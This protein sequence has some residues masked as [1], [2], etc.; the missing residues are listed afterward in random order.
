M[1]RGREGTVNVQQGYKYIKSTILLV[2]SAVYS[3]T[4]PF[5]PLSTACQLLRIASFSVTQLPGSSFHCRAGETTAVR[6]WPEHWTGHL[7]FDLNR[8][9]TKSCG[10]LI[11]S[12]H[13]IFTL[14]G[15]EAATEIRVQGE[16]SR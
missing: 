6:P 11:F 14:S 4:P 12:S 5:P 9:L 3:L 15:E 16:S 10:D 13:T 7:V 8:Q 2:F 1:I